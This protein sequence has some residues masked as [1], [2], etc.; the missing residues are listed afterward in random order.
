MEL[1]SQKKKKIKTIL[2]LPNPMRSVT[3]GE[4]CRCVYVSV[5]VC[6]IQNVRHLDAID[7]NGFF[8]F[9]GSLYRV[10]CVAA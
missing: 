7:H 1:S 2:N 8:L 6:I 10:C 9:R 4:S 5:C 3:M